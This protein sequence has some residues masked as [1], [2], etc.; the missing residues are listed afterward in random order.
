MI[1][2][3][4]AVNVAARGGVQT[5]P[6]ASPPAVVSSSISQAWQLAMFMPGS[7]E[8]TISIVIAEALAACAAVLAP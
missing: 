7:A 2:P 6:Q 5:M 3:I 4:E 1:G 8:V